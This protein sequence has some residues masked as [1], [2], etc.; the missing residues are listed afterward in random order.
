MSTGLIIRRALCTNLRGPR[1]RSA[2]CHSRYA[3]KELY[4]RSTYQISLTKTNGYN[5]TSI[6]CYSTQNGRQWKTIDNQSFKPSKNSFTLMS[7]NI[8]A[9]H[10]IDSQPSLYRNHNPDSLQWTHRFDVL[11]QEIDDISPDILCLQEVQQSHLSEISAH[12]NDQGY[13]TSLFKKRT[14]LQVDGCAIFFKKHLFDLIE[15][16]FVDYFQPEIKILNRCNVAVIA[17]FALK[18]KPDIN[19]VVSTT[20]LL[21]NPK[22]H[23]IRLAQCSV[24]LAELDRIARDDVNQCKTVPIILTGDFN[25]KQE[26]EVFR[27]IIGEDIVPSKVFEKMNFRFGQ[28]RQNLLPREIGISDHCQHIDVAENLNRYQTALRTSAQNANCESRIVQQRVISDEEIDKSDLPFDTGVIKHHLNLLPTICP[29]KPV[30]ID[31]KHA[32]TYHN[33]WI[34]V[35]YIFFSEANNASSTSK[36]Q[37]LE[38]YQLPNAFECFSNGTIPNHQLGSDH[39]SVAARFSIE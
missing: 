3:A 21:F 10:Y 6:C 9:Q 17:K 33:K 12:F 20:H 27:L 7:Y 18:S 23:D 39:Y 29:T 5:F 36:L 31:E 14:G 28:N 30:V 34:M 2:S 35:D 8:L 26:S 38:N 24:L 16:H 13:D 22:R 4:S 1:S 32:S 25:V 19:F 11:K 37:L 15:F